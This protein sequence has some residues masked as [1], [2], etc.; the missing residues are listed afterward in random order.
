MELTC[1]TDDYRM[2]SSQRTTALLALTSFAIYFGMYAQGVVAA[3]QQLHQA[4]LAQTI[5]QMLGISYQPS[6]PTYPAVSLK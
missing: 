5:A 1:S 4:Q 2:T 6:H 3:K